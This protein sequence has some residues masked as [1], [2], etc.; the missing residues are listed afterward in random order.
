MNEIRNLSPKWEFIADTVMGGVSTGS[1]T[2]TTIDERTAHRLTGQVS[3]ENDGGFI[4]MAFDLN[5]NDTPFYGRGW[6]GIELEVLGNEEVYEVRLRTSQLTRPWQSF[7]AEFLAGARWKTV[8]MPFG[9]FTPH[10]HELSFDPAQL[11]RIG[12]L[13]IGREFQVDVAVSALR[14]Y[15]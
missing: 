9:E 14:F 1:V 11:R 15:R 7:R 4:Q 13:A 5:S 8:R 12:V 2:A 6:A 10:R 3:L